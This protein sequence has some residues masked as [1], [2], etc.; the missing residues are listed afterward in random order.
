[1]WL[2]ILGMWS[3]NNDNE[4]ILTFQGEVLSQTQ[5]KKNVKFPLNSIALRI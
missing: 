2:L 4:K 3:V 5:G 1:M